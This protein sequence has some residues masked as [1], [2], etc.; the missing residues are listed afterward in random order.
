[1][2]LYNIVM[3]IVLIC[4]GAFMV[5]KNDFT[6]AWSTGFIMLVGLFCLIRGIRLGRS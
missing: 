2:K 6:F 3:G 1:M 5:Y 4:L